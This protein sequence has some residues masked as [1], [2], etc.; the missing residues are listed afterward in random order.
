M[1]L[2]MLLR[3]EELATSEANCVA[4]CSV[5]GCA[6]RVEEP[7]DE[8]ERVESSAVRLATLFRKDDVANSGADCVACW[9]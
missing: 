6:S 5:A 8:R 4:D 7:L 1:C 3:T 9:A 2:A